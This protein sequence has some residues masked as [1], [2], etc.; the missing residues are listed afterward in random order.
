MFEKQMQISPKLEFLSS[1]GGVGR[2]LPQEIFLKTNANGAF[3][4]H[5]FVDCPLI[6]FPKTVPIKFFASKAKRKMIYII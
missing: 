2:G 5:F 4:T 1:C 6:F 3:L